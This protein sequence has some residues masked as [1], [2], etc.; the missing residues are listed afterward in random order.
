MDFGSDG[1]LDCWITGVF[2]NSNTPKTPLLHCPN[3][4]LLQRL[5]L[6]NPIGEQLGL[7]GELFAFAEPTHAFQLQ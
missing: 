6:S 2:G 4:P 3:N 7:P 1:L 5:G